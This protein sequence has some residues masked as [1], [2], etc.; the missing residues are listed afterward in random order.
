MTAVALRPV[1]TAPV[2]AAARA[3]PTSLPWDANDLVGVIGANALAAVAL[4][5]A[6]FGVSGSA[7]LPDA[8]N[9][10]IVGIAGVVLQGC[11]NIVWLMRGRRVIGQRRVQTIAQL[12]LLVGLDADAAPSAAPAGSATRGQPRTGADLVTVPGTS[13]FHREDCQ[14]VTGKDVV[15]ARLADHLAAGR[16]ACGVCE[17]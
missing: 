10:T 5:V 17:P 1:E 3:A 16:Q 7:V 9:Y 8:V 13:R 2:R 11:G 14:L 15:P 6:W 12:E 4:V